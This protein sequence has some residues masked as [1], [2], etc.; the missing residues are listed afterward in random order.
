MRMSDVKVGDRIKMFGA[1]REITVTELTE[2]GFRYTVDEPYCLAPFL[3]MHDGGEHFG[4]DGEV[5][6][7]DYYR[8]ANAALRGGSSSAPSLEDRKDVKP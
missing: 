6:D 5:A 1:T 3:G 4:V 7:D 2:R 8:R